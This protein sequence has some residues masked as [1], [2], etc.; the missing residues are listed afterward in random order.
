MDTKTLIKRL[1]SKQREVL[2]NIACNQDGGHNISTLRSLAKKGLIEEYK[3][4]QGSGFSIL[5]Y[6]VPVHVHIV[7]CEL[8]SEEIGDGEDE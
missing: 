6:R 1:S 3:E 5:R 4:D 8:C 7:W 2:N